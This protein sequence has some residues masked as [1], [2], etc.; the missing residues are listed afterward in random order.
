MSDEHH[1]PSV[2]TPEVDVYTEI[3]NRYPEL[4]ENP[5]DPTWRPEYEWAYRTQTHMLNP[6]Q[7]DWPR[8]P[9]I[10]KD[11][12]IIAIYDGE[13]AKVAARA[14]ADAK[15]Q[16]AEQA[17]VGTESTVE[18]NRIVGDAVVLD[19]VQGAKQ[20]DRYTLISRRLGETGITGHGVCTY[21]NSW[22]IQNLPMNA[23]TEF[24]VVSEHENGRQQIQGAWLSVPIGNVS[25]EEINQQEA[26]KAKAERDAAFA[27]REAEVQAAYDRIAAH[28]EALNRQQAEAERMNAEREREL[29]TKMREHEIAVAKLPET[30]ARN[31]RLTVRPHTDT[32][33]L[34][35]IRWQRGIRGCNHYK[36]EMNEATVLGHLGEWGGRKPATHEYLRT[37]TL[38]LGVQ[39]VIDITPVTEHGDGPSARVIIDGVVNT[40]EPNVD[41]Q[42]DPS[43]SDRRTVDTE[44]AAP[45]RDAGV[46][47]SGEPTEE[48][49]VIQV[50][51][52]TQEQPPPAPRV[53]PGDKKV[54]ETKADRKARRK[55]AKRAKG[56][57]GHRRRRRSK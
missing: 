39:T 50:E 51:E 21:G 37:L 49:P 14:A 57:R 16:E 12:I 41:A 36:F 54:P 52:Q 22:V 3:R 26:E 15:R 44:M 25:L 9:Q 47:E 24:A 5:N 19:L 8:L 33:L 30:V 13:A 46:E 11:K 6:S 55:A 4:P 53:I 31:V 56:K 32:T 2:D 18:I 10:I 1:G 42:R 38:P 7:Y 45:Q 34:A 40:E 20:A 48:L 35:D 27:A 17:L 43:P 28:M 23:V 29:A